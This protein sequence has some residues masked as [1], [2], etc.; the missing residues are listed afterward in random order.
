[1]FIGKKIYFPIHQL[2]NLLSSYAFSKGAIKLM[3]VLKYVPIILGCAAVNQL[4]EAVWFSERVFGRIWKKGLSV[5]D[6]EIVKRDHLQGIKLSVGVSLLSASLIGLF[7]Y[8]QDV[9]TVW[10]GALVGLL[11]SAFIATAQ[12]VNYV[13]EDRSAAF[14]WVISG[15]S[16]LSY[17]LMGLLIGWWS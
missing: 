7:C 15:Y 13:Y 11:S 2:L 6:K 4:L 5:S 12:A 14:Y 9:H 8:L 1:M 10:E 17:T 16:L 3:T